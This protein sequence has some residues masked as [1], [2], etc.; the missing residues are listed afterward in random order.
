MGKVLRLTEEE[1]TD[2]VQK[3]I[4]EQKLNEGPFDSLG[5]LYRGVKGV[6]RGYGMDYFQSMS[7]LDR[8]IKQLKKLDQPNLKVMGELSQLK[9]KVANLNMPQQRK[10]ALTNLIENALFHFDKYNKINDQ[11]IAQIKTLNLD[12]W[13]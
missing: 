4:E 2:L 10:Q 7:R 8:L 1:L 5:D 3:I 13:K 6:K 9:G 12:S 11:I